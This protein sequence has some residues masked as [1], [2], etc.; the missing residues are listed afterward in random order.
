MLFGAQAATWLTPIPEFSSCE[1]VKA[2]GGYPNH[3]MTTGVGLSSP[4]AVLTQQFNEVLSYLEELKHE[5]Q[6]D[7]LERS[8]TEVPLHSWPWWSYLG[9]VVPQVSS[10]FNSQAALCAR[11]GCCRRWALGEALLTWRRVQEKMNLLLWL[12]TFQGS[13]ALAPDTVE[14]RFLGGEFEGVRW[15]EE[16]H[17]EVSIGERMVYQTWLQYRSAEEIFDLSEEALKKAL[18]GLGESEQDSASGAYASINEVV[19]P[20]TLSWKIC[21]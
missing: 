13:L 1:E 15:N 11:N 14:G 9:S 4:Q 21:R 8:T 10:T 17:Y 19:V 16:L 18:S 7:M 2:E 20:R 6:K 5:L 12:G 3:S